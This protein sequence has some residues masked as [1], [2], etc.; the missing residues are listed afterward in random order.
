MAYIIH[1]AQP[2]SS[3]QHGHSSSNL[4]FRGPQS[5]G[6]ISYAIKSQKEEKNREYDEEEE[7]EKKAALCTGKDL[8]G[9]ISDL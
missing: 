6:N 1:K 5:D 7:I 3:L 8:P 4:S 2:S 9:V